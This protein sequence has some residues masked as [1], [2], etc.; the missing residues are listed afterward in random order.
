MTT[1]MKSSL[2]STCVN[3]TVGCLK[4]DDNCEKPGAPLPRVETG[5]CLK[6]KDNLYGFSTSGIDVIDGG[7]KGDNSGGVV[8]GFNTGCVTD[9]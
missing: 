9:R 4:G 8:V 7:L 3:E 6:G 2:T 1:G 5:G